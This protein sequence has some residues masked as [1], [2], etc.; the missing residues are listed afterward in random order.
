[1]LDWVI[2]TREVGGEG[3]SID[4]QAQ[5]A[6]LPA[7]AATLEVHA[8]RALRVTGRVKA[9][10]RDRF[11][12]AGQVQARLVQTCVVTLEPLE[13]DIRE[14]IEVELWPREA[15]AEYEEGGSAFATS[16]PEPYEAGMLPLGQLVVEHLVAAMDPFPRQDGAEVDWRDGKDEAAPAN[17]FAVLARLKGKGG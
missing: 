17:P 9:L 2:E 4:R 14:G 15:L 6:E 13:T 10:S 16:G 11:A 7:L 12:I 3:R 5:E 8:V 1:M